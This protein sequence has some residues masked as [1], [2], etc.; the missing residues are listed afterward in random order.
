MKFNLIK[1]ISSD[2][3]TPAMEL[4]GNKRIVVFDC[5]SIIDYSD[6]II[7]LDLGEYK[8]KIEGKGLCADSFAFGQTDITGVIK[9]L[10]FV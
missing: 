9:G 6:N 7:A 3:N 8:V 10:E 1:N 5:K 4:Y 2:I